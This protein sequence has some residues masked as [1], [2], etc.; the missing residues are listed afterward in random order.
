M[1]C[2]LLQ[3]AWGCLRN[4]LKKPCIC[5]VSTQTELQTASTILLGQTQKTEAES[6]FYFCIVGSESTPVNSTGLFLRCVTED[7]I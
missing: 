4:Y 6:S 1:M 3:E 2:V 7:Y 5:I